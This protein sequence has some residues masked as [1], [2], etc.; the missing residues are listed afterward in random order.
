MPAVPDEFERL[1][2]YEPFGGETL[3]PGQ[4]RYVLLDVFASRPLEGNQLA[5]FTDA[6]GI[7]EH[8]MQAIARELRLSETTFVL[9][10][11]QDG[12]VWVRIFTPRIELPFAGHPVLGTAVAV[13]AALERDEVVLETG[14][15]PVPVSI[16]AG[17]G[18][19]GSGRM[20]QP[21]P[22][23]REFQQPAELLAA[24]G[25]ERS[26]L[27]IEI[28]D[29][30]PSHVYVELGAPAE[31]AALEPD[32]R[33]LAKVAGQAGV[34]CV[35]ASD[36]RYKS[37]MFAPGAGIDEDPATGSAAG[38]LA[39]HLARHGR[40]AFGEEIEIVQGVEILRPSLLRA[41]A[42]GSSDRIESVHVAGEAVVLACGRMRVS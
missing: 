16:E 10:A 33:A 6:R 25:V 12:D 1:A 38:P 11:R 32:L 2:A 26:L 35:A 13:A 18:H 3:A 29:N 21:V 27:P 24:L 39:V 23:W 9:P 14:S 5:V 20:S 8:V 40:I 31:V 42:R 19:A 34:S 4:R 30:G 7:D 28:Y 37:R 17:G 22:S 41:C 36:G 15:G